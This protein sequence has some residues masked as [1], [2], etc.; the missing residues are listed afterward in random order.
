VRSAV[1]EKPSSR[2]S[3]AMM[4]LCAMV[5]FGATTAQVHVATSNTKSIYAYWCDTKGHSADAMCQRHEMGAQL[6]KTKSSEEKKAIIAKMKTFSSTASRKE[7]LAAKASFCEGPGKGTSLC[8]FTTS[9]YHS[10]NRTL[11]TDNSRTEM[12]QWYC[13]K[14][15]SAESAPCKAHTLRESLKQPNLSLEAKK[16]IYSKIRQVGPIPIV[17]MQAATAEWCKKPNH[18]DTSVCLSQKSSNEMKEVQTWYCG[19]PESKESAWC[20]RQGLM[21]ELTALAGSK[22]EAALAKR[23][24]ISK[25]MATL[26]KAISSSSEHVKAMKEF[27][28]LPGKSNYRSCKN[29]VMTSHY[30]TPGSRIASAMAT[31][32]SMVHKSSSMVKPG[33]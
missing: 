16:E 15:D 3:E 13:G 8:S 25:E 26:N 9:S 7:Y 24:E 17:E 21:K 11:S 5:L 2:I 12:M 29:G 31:S 23:K 18:M 32:S 4:L 30:G 22:D 33:Q 10:R 20:R 14:P 19:K 1:S 27:C 28:T 6:V